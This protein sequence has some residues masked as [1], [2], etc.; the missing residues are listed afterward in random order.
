MYYIPLHVSSPTVLIIRRSNGI[1]QH[2]VS[3][4]ST[5][6]KALSSPSM[7][8][9][10][11]LQREGKLIPE[12]YPGETHPLFQT[13]INTQPPHTTWK[14]QLCLSLQPGH[15]SSLTTPYLQPTANQSR[16]KFSFTTLMYA[17][18]TSNYQPTNETN[19]TQENTSTTT[20]KRSQ[21]LI[22]TETVTSYNKMTKNF[23][24][25]THH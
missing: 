19:Y 10:Q 6:L 3:S 4:P 2:L 12:Q 22:S 17:N 18:N 1:I 13:A 8:Y 24:P 5:S 23:T 16:Y 21:L 20:H 15:Y 7:L 25:N 14:D 11:T 9:I